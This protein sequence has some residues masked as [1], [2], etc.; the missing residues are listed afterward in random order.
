MLQ[1]GRVEAAEQT[2]ADIY[3]KYGLKYNIY[4]AREYGVKGDGR[5]DDLAAVEDLFQ[6]ATDELGRQVPVF[7]FPAGRYLLSNKCRWDAH[8]KMGDKDKGYNYSN[9]F[10]GMGPALTQFV[11]QP[12]APGFDDPGHPKQMFGRTGIKRETLGYIMDGFGFRSN[13]DGSNPGSIAFFWQPHFG[14]CRNIAAAGGYAGLHM[15]RPKGQNVTMENITCEGGLYGLWLQGD[16]F[17]YKHLTCTGFSKAGVRVDHEPVHFRGTSTSLSNFTSR[18][19][20]PAVIVGKMSAVTIIGGRLESDP[21]GSEFA[22]NDTV[23]GSTLI[24]VETVGYRHII[25]GVPAEG[26]GLNSVSFFT[27]GVDRLTKIEQKR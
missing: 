11:L 24:N 26:S 12:R 10:V 3:A 23:G 27:R 15:T 7:F 21:A 13:E 17:N 9:L 1:S 18:G 20:G 8:G 5:T 25:N 6:R 2:V 16:A 4:N 22:V 19:N 14:I